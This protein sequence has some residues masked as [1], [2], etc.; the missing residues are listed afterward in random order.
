MFARLRRMLGRRSSHRSSPNRSSPNKTSSTR[1]SVRTGHGRHGSFNATKYLPNKEENAYYKTLMAH[2][3]NS[4]TKHNRE[5]QKYS[6][7][8][9]KLEAKQKSMKKMNKSRRSM[10]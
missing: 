1:R 5:Y 3:D 8:Q 6:L 4:F 9:I 10:L 2:N 7:A